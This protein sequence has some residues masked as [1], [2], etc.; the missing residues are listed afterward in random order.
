MFLVKAAVPLANIINELI[1][2]KIEQPMSKSLLASP[3][4]SASDAF[5][6]L[7]AADSNLK[8]RS[9]N[10]VPSLSG[11]YGQLRFNVEKGSPYLFG[12]NIY[13]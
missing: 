5:A 10:I 6:L 12:G 3:K 7:G 2:V 11:E 13:R 1:K 8:T 4:Q 9:D